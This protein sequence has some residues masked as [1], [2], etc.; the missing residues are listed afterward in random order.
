MKV[1]AEY[2]NEL[3]K[4]YVAQMRDDPRSVIEFVESVQ[5]PLPRE[6]KW[7]LIVSSMFGCP[8]GCRMCDAG[9]DFAGPLSTDELLAQIDALVVRRYPDRRI[10]SSKFKVQFAR[11]GE[12]SLNPSVLEAVRL[13]PTIY[14][15]PGL[16]ASLSTV[17]PVRAANFFDELITIKERS[18]GAGKFQLQFSVHTTDQDKRNELIPTRTWT[19]E[20]MARYGDRFCCPEEWDR[21]VTL[22]FAPIIGY[23]IDAS[24]I[25]EHFNP[26]KFLIKLTPLNPTLRSMDGGL[27]SAITSGPSRTSEMLINDFSRNGFEVILSI[28]EAEEN[29]IGS[30]CGQFIQRTLREG[31]RPRD[32]YDLGRYQLRE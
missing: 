25:R 31:R 11:M 20:Q 4:V 10:P 26:E 16:I 22:N 30:N 21:K 14:Q 12:P 8:I 9:G 1:L 3:A 29:R 24:V 27:S 32:A 7:V 17:A 13:L 28:G 19:F 18:Y 15:A 5:P 6:E 2:G 23:P